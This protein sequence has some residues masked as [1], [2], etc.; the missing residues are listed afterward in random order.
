MRIVII[1]GRVEK[2]ETTG[3]ERIRATGIYDQVS[4]CFSLCSILVL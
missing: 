4:V 2:K 3:K 1:F